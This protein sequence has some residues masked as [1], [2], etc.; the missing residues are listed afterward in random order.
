M[1][2]KRRKRDGRDSKTQRKGQMKPGK[3]RDNMRQRT[4]TDA[5]GSNKP[6]QR[7]IKRQKADKTTTDK[8]QLKETINNKKEMKKRTN[9][10]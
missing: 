3:E 10:K 5:G 1:S 6:R 8:K 4:Q 2:S 9:T 7:D